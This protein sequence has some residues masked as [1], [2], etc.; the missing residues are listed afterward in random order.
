MFASDLHRKLFDV[1]D[2]LHNQVPCRAETLR[3][4]L[5]ID[6]R[7]ISLMIAAFPVN[8]LVNMCGV[9]SHH[10]GEVCMALIIASHESR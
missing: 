9:L 5:A 7:L 4:F 10:E 6:I 1:G 8:T 2:R 3:I